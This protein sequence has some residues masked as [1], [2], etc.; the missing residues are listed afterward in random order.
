MK[1]KMHIEDLTLR[2]QLS[3]MKDGYG[4]DLSWTRLNDKELK[5]DFFKTLNYYKERALYLGKNEKKYLKQLEEIKL[6]VYGG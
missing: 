2:G 6:K 4:D 1:I 3:K 5:E